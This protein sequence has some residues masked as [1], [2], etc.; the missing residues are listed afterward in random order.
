MLIPP[1][2][3]I[4]LLLVAVWAPNVEL[5]LHQ[6]LPNVEKMVFMNAQ[7]IISKYPIGVSNKQS[8]NATSFIIYP[9]NFLSLFTITVLVRVNTKTPLN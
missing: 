2:K 8:T 3:L 6:H 7:D 4:A 5:K 9:V 1:L